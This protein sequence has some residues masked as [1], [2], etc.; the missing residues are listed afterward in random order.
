MFC[1]TTVGFWVS[2]TVTVKDVIA[3]PQ[4]LEDLAQTVVVPTGKI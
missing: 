2:V 4:L 3:S 1:V